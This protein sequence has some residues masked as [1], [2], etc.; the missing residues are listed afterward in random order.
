MMSPF[1]A[2][3]GTQGCLWL[4][5]LFFFLAFDFVLR[6]CLQGLLAVTLKG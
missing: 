5:T 6:V 4:L 2:A 3:Q 1:R